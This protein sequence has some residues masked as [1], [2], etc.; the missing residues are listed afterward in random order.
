MSDP[1]QLPKLPGYHMEDPTTR[2]T[3]RIKT[4]EY[5][6]GF[7]YV[8]PLEGNENSRSGIA[9][10][11]HPSILACS[12]TCKPLLSFLR[13][14]SLRARL[15]VA[16]PLS[17]INPARVGAFLPPPS[18]FAISCGKGSDEFNQYARTQ[19]LWHDHPGRSHW[20]PLPSPLPSDRYRSF[21]CPVPAPS[22]PNPCSHTC[23]G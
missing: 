14:V 16:Q 4:L 12:C 20:C 23:H 19:G 21:L 8:H 2:K 5:K 10:P 9:Q 18:F 1:S 15:S 11:H 7:T 3:T 17:A 6:S 22:P 13:T